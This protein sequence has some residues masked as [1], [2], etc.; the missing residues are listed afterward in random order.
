MKYV[1]TAATRRGIADIERLLDNYNWFMLKE[2]G[3]NPPSTFE[4]NTSGDHQNC[5]NTLS[6]ISDDI[7]A[8][9]D[10]WFFRIGAASPYTYY[11]RIPQSMVGK[12]DSFEE[13]YH[14]THTPKIILY[15]PL[16]VEEMGSFN[17]DFDFSFE[18]TI[19][20]GAYTWESTTQADITAADSS[21]T[22]VDGE[23]TAADLLDVTPC[24][25]HDYKY[26][27]IGESGSYSYYKKANATP[28]Q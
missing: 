18:I 16:P 7:L 22:W 24:V 6:D 25:E 21:Y 14:V 3:S 13:D 28:P 4:A 20:S 5:Y 2:F 15:S 23:N 27:R 12:V 10:Q 26:M 1:R 11:Q 17:N 9:T 8:N 19:V